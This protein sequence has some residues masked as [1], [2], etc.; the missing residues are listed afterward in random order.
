MDDLH[1]NIIMVSIFYVSRHNWFH[2][3]HSAYGSRSCSLLED[4]MQALTE[5]STSKF[6]NFTLHILNLLD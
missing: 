5:R 2:P 4:G 1:Q 3:K 6:A